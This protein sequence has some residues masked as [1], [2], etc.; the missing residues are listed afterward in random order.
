MTLFTYKILLKMTIFLLVTKDESK[1]PYVK[2]VAL[3]RLI[4]QRK[5][6]F[7]PIFDSLH[8]N[9]INM[10]NHKKYLKFN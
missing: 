1:M 2:W 4:P 9:I 5:L 6:T 8:I 7:V 10:C 3:G